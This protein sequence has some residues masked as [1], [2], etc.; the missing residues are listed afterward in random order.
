MSFKTD[1][2]KPAAFD[3]LSRIADSP[4]TCEAS[5][6]LDVLQVPFVQNLPRDKDKTGPLF[7]ISLKD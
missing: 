4:W 2:T 3:E 5:D 6:T 1:Q 7:P